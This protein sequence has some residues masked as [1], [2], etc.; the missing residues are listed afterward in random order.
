[1]DIECLWVFFSEHTYMYTVFVS[2]TTYNKKVHDQYVA[3]IQ[4]TDFTFS[5]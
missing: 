1:M 4:I 5:I 3:D 2:D